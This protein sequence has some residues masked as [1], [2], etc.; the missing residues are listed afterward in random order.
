MILP[1]LL[2]YFLSFPPTAQAADCGG[3][4]PCACGDTV[5]ADYVLPADLGPC[6]VSSHGLVI[7]NG[8]SVDLNGKIVSGAGCDDCETFGLYFLK[9]RK[10]AVFD[11]KVTGF[12]RG[13][14]FRAARGNLLQNVETFQNGDLNNP[15]GGYGIDLAEGAVDNHIGGAS[16]HDNTDEG[17]H[18]GGG[19]RRNTLVGSTVFNNG[20][21]NIYLIESIQNRI[22]L[23]EAS[24]GQNSLFMKDARNNE[25]LGNVFRDGVALIRDD[26]RN[27]S[28]LGNDLAGTNFHFQQTD[29]N[30]PPKGNVVVGGQ[31]AG[32]TKCFRFT[33][34]K[35]TRIA[36][37]SLSD[38]DE[39]VFATGP[40]ARDNVF[41]NTQFDDVVR[42]ENGAEIELGWH[43]DVRVEDTNGSPVE[44]ARVILRTA[45]NK[46]AFSELTG[47]EGKIATQDVV[48]LVQ[49]EGG[50]ELRTPHAL[51]TTKTGFQ[52]HERQI[53]VADNI[54][55]VVTL[56]AT[57]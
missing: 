4:T 55:V 39:S 26:S 53:D 8:V 57:D 6:P 42:L 45:G 48:Q 12:F 21:E 7:G 38:C 23:N 31:I 18:F 36:D 43:V 30:P 41:I 22:I 24:G 20:V 1:L 15:S 44:R 34:A 47:S 40:N 28:F 10:A 37:V 27:N 33:G 52:T 5:V 50:P 51:L 14:R 2:L 49:G 13:V 17:I 46:V 32:G 25:I 29:P 19:S 11:G 3:A 54:S 56:V 9:S 16:I 35:Q